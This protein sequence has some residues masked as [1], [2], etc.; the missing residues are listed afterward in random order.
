MKIT[1]HILDTARGAPAA[2]VRVALAVR[3]DT[4]EWREIA[5]GITD[6]DGR[7][8]DLLPGAGDGADAG[9]GAGGGDGGLPRH[10]RSP[11]LKER[12]GDESGDGAGDGA[13]DGDGTGAGADAD[14]AGEYRL[15]FATADYHRDHGVA[16]FH[17]RVEVVFTVA[18]VAADNPDAHYHIP[19]LLSPFGYTTYRG[20]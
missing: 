1:S 9:D 18:T 12:G 2:G 6:A 10:P 17:P 11:R 16:C 8:A 4:G 20:S 15:T 3:G 14:A 5:T 7:V 19:L 13:G